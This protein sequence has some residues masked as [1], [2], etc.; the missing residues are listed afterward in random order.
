M[1][2]GERDS[3]HNPPGKTV[4]IW[5]RGAAFWILFASVL[6]NSKL[7]LVIAVTCAVMLSGYAAYLFITKQ[8]YFQFLQQQKQANEEKIAKYKEGSKKGK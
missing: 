8:A 7:A 5:L 2:L 3:D 1:F 4:F 6:L